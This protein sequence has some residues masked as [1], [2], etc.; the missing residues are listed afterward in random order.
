M[1]QKISE[2]VFLNELNS[3]VT[4]IYYLK[5]V[6]VATFAALQKHHV[7][8]EGMLLKTN[9]VTPG[10]KVIIYKVFVTRN[11]SSFSVQTELMQLLLQ[12]TLLNV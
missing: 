10:A 7:L 3:T 8:L 2:K 12:S 11:Q 1:C 5:K 9:M 6:L 4:C